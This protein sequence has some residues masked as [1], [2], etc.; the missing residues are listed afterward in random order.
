MITS[1]NDNKDDLDDDDSVAFPSN[2]N[3]ITD[4]IDVADAA[5]GIDGIDVA[6]DDS[7]EG[8]AFISKWII[9]TVDN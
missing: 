1:F 5:E 7:D 2:Q 3:I 4:G 8:F 9:D 6:D